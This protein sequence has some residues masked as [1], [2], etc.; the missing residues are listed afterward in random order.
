[1]PGRTAKMFPIWSTFTSQPNALHSITSQ[2]LTSLS[3]WL[4]A[5][6]RMPVEFGKA[7]HDEH[8]VWRVE[9]NLSPLIRSTLE[10]EDIAQAAN[11]DAE[12]D[13]PEQVV[14]WFYSLICGACI[15]GYRVNWSWSFGH[16]KWEHLPFNP[17][18]GILY[19]NIGSRPF[20]EN[21]SI[22]ELLGP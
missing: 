1:M 16:R 22:R 14:S 15:S 10:A 21:Q 19:S 3:S 17:P 18:N 2:S 20:L 4:N 12:H 8:V 9:F 7:P 6:R 13:L 5:R 11:A